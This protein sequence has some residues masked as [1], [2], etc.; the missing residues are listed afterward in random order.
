MGKRRW[1]DEG[2]KV[3]TNTDAA[4]WTY[5]NFHVLESPNDRWESQIL[6]ASQGKAEN[7]GTGYKVKALR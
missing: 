5:K 3:S 6:R 7:D 1:D 2:G 4:G